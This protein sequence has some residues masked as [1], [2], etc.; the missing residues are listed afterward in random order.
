MAGGAD[1]VGDHP[2]HKPANEDRIRIHSLINQDTVA[3]LIPKITESASRLWDASLGLLYPHVCQLCQNERAESDEGYVCRACQAS[4]ADIRPPFCS[5]CGLPVLGNVTHAFV[6]ANCRDQ[7]WD[8]DSARGAVVAEGPVREAIHRY[9]YHRAFW[10]EPFLVAHLLRQALPELR[11]RKWDAVAPVPLH[12]AKERER[13]FNQAERLG[14]HLAE[15]VSAPL[16]TGWVRRTE[17]TLQQAKLTREERLANI[18]RAFAPKSEA[19]LKGARIL[20]VD[21]VLTTG[22]TTSAVARVLKKMGAAE[23]HV[24]AVARAVG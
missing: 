18:R 3:S 10:F 9:K 24:W 21:D 23:V 13:E 16:E 22:A 15:A 12:P 11:G 8:F 6:C 14:R 5:I 4:V 2:G 7:K 1:S 20:V 19:S 17:P